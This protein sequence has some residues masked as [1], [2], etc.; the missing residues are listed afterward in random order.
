M[1]KLAN[2]VKETSITSGTGSVLLAGGFGAFQTFSSAIG[3]GNTTFYTIENDTR[4]EVG[5]GT[6]ATDTNTLSRDT[7]LSSSSGGSKID[8]NG[9]S[10]VFCTLPAEKT[11]FF[12]DNNYLPEGKP[13]TLTRQS[14]GNFIHAFVDNSSDKT[15]ALHMENSSDPTWKFGLK[16][17]PNSE[18]TAPQYGYVY[19]ANGTAG[20]YGD[21]DAYAYIDSNLGFYISH[22]GSNLVQVTKDGG[23]EIKNGSAN[24]NALTVKGA[25]AQSYPLQVWTNNAGT[26]LS[27]VGSD[28]SLA[29]GKATA[30]NYT[31]DV[32]GTAN[33][34]TV[35]FSDGSLQTTA[36]K[37]S[38]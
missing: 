28:G 25:A 15:V 4:W 17:S 9:V 36:S 1:L 7:V 16:D 33:V 30:P 3:N 8:L 23:T 31:L 10:I 27:S 5:I 37:P 18:T 20:L 2:R 29:L 6:Y 19:G 35:R 34:T 24:V 11:V 14:A 22:E 13:L 38:G 26:T 32:N 12:G 21:S